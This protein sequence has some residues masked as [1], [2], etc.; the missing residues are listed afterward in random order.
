VVAHEPVGLDLGRQEIARSLAHFTPRTITALLGANGFAVEQL[1][2]FSLE[3]NPYGRLQSTFS[4]AG[5]RWHNLYD[6]LRAPGSTHAV[7]RDL[8]V[9]GAAA[10]LTPLCV[11][12]ATLESALGHGGTIEVWARPRWRPENAGSSAAVPHRLGEL[13]ALRLLL[14]PREHVGDPSGA[15]STHRDR[16]LGEQ[17]LPTWS[18]RPTTTKVEASR[19]ACFSRSMVACSTQLRDTQLVPLP[20]TFVTAILWCVLLWRAIGREHGHLRLA[21]CARSAARQIYQVRMGCISSPGCSPR[22]DSGVRD[23]AR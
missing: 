22:R 16:I 11:A 4:A 15:L 1:S 21:L 13:V 12:L 3:Q 2:H 6:Q 9:S 18:I 7:P 23:H 17:H 5:G 20:F 19:S 8:L 14:I 10:A